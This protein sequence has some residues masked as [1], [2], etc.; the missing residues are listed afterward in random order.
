MSGFKDMLKYF[1]MRE[2]LSQSELA[3]KLGVSTSRISMYEAGKREPD[4]ETEELIADFFNTDLN[5]LRG[6]DVEK[7]AMDGKTKYALDLFMSLS[8]VG[9][10][11]VIEYIELLKN[12]HPRHIEEYTS[13]H[14]KSPFKRAGRKHEEP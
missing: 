11:I 12:V 2:N 13:A 14:E 3:E 7:L 9:Q 5:T 1:R 6:K 10:D 8:N 4:F